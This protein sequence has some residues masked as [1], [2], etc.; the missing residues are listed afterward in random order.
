MVTDTLYLLA[1]HAMLIA[2]QS[3]INYI[4][5]QVLDDKQLLFTLCYENE[6]LRHGKIGT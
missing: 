2:S 3:D 5:D 6:K 1:D 4:P